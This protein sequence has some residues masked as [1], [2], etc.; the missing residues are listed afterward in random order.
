MNFNPQ[1][2]NWRILSDI[3]RVGLMRRRSGLWDKNKGYADCTDTIGIS[4]FSFVLYVPVAEL[5][6]RPMACISSNC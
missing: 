5:Q 6:S 4:F 2:E 3:S 1:E